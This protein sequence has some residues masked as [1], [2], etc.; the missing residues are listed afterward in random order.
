MSSVLRPSTVDDELPILE[1]LT[2]IFS[3]A[4]SDHSA[5]RSLLRWKYWQPRADFQE[6]RSFVMERNGQI[7]A[8]LGL[9]PVTV[10]AGAKSERGIH[11]MDWAS[12][13]RAPGTGVA[14]LQRIAKNQDFVYA[15][16]GSELTRS[17]LPRFGFSTIAETVTWARP[18]R[19]WRQVAQHQ[20]RDLRLPLRFA[21]N[22][23]WSRVPARTTGQGWDAVQA[24][25]CDPDDSAT[26]YSERN[27]SFF[28]YL[29]Q[30]PVARSMTFY[31]SKKGRRAGYFALSIVRQQARL[32]GAWLDD[33]TPANWRAV[34]QLAQQAALKHTV[35]SEFVARCATQSSAEAAGP[36]G[37]RV[38]GRSP[39]FLFRKDKGID[40]PPLQYQLVD[41]DAVFHQ[42][43][44]AG[45]LT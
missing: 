13:P 33:P 38:R 43:E 3:P 19:P 2:R 23:W 16:G 18:I 5:L 17:I 31:V 6:P 15:I 39:V 44:T 37:L 45:F 27:G 42:P 10:S 11:M 12:D 21:R 4:V 25:Y 26:P 28:R 40:F 41:N 14:L 7:V 20:T 24:D 22:I 34:F 8:H 36:A 29:Q 35:A 9:W 32:A 1:L 30:C